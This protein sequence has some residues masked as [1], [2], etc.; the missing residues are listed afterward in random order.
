ML[1]AEATVPKT[2]E[3][4]IIPKTKIVQI[5][6]TGMPTERLNIQ[7]KLNENFSAEQLGI[8]EENNKAFSQWQ[9]MA[10]NEAELK[11]FEEKMKTMP[12]EERNMW[13]KARARY[14]ESLG[15]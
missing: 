10:E 11:A 13:E 3:E 15:K 9:K 1:N 2:A 7:Q 4:E 6:Q 5:S 12:D 8:D 14:L